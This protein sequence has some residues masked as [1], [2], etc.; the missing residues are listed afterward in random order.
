MTSSFDVVTLGEAM[1]L[2]LTQEATPLRSADRFVRGVAGAESNVAV[3]VARLGLRSS[4][5]G[6]LGDDALGHGVLDRLRAEGV[7]LSRVVVDSGAA[8]GV[9]VRDHHAERRVSVAYARTGSAATRMTVSDVS[10]DWLGSAE[11]V[12]LT[13]ITPALGP[14]PA[15]AVAFAA[16]EAALRGTRVALDL[17]LRRRLW[18][19]E[20]AAAALIPLLPSVDILFGG[21]DELAAVSGHRS[22]A[23]CCRWALDQ[24]CRVVVVKKGPE[25]ATASTAHGSVDAAASL[26]SVVDTVGAGDAFVAGYLAATVAGAGLQEALEQACRVGAAAVQV[27]GDLDGLPYGTKGLLPPPGVGDVDR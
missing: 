11:V 14:G 21:L 23:E 15:E 6:R 1:A 7:D 19:D 2:F 22:V 5:C 13:G 4:W 10:P 9:L 26:T 8:T 17:N 12:H 25:G 3:G 24:G 27:A 20:E 18:S 16:T